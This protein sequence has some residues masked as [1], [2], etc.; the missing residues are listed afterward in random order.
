[1]LKIIMHFAKIIVTAFIVLVF[2]SCRSNS[3]SGYYENNSEIKGSGTIVTETRN[4]DQDFQKIEASRGVEV[5]IEQT[6]QKSVIVDAD[7]NLMVHIITKVENGTLVIRTDNNYVS[8]KAPKITIKMPVINSV[9]SSSGSSISSANVLKSTNFN[10]DSSSGSSINVNI[11][12]D[13]IEL[14]SSSGSKLIAR[15]KAL[16]LKT[17][18][19]SG[20]KINAGDLLANEVKSD[21]SSGA[22]TVI[23]PIVSLDADASSG[24]TI[25]YTKTPKSITKDE[26]S[27]GSVSEQ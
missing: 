5:I 8:K 16:K 6:D 13:N 22:N 12:S 26:S 23:T 1:M 3:D 19:S 11:E 18:S 7:D 2:G 24:G 10:A 17:D 9:S 21:V 14:S 25:R 15:G 4:I 20:S 27:G